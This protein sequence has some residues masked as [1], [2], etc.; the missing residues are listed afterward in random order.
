MHNKSEILKSS[1][2]A[3]EMKQKKRSRRRLYALG[4][5]FCTIALL[6]GFSY[7]SQL[8][9]TRIERVVITGNSTIE[10]DMILKAVQDELFGKYVYLF[11]KQNGLIYPKKK[12]EAHL[13]DVFKRLLDVKIDLTDLHTLNVQ[14][15][16]RDARYLWCGHQYEETI[17]ETSNTQCYYIDGNG[18]I[19]SEAPYFSG[20]VFLKFYGTG[21]FNS[22]ITPVGQQ[23]LNLTDFNALLKF[24]DDV[25]ALGLKTYGLVLDPVGEYH[26]YI[27]PL[28]ADRKVHTK[29]IFN[30]K[31]DLDAIVGNLKAALATEP[32]ATEFKKKFDT[33]LYIDLRFTNKV[34][35]KF[36]DQ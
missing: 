12:I 7:L 31:N 4:I 36:S 21:L 27:S 32:F 28:T 1:S 19:F 34:Y 14:V 33:L 22:S 9:A 15:T 2:R 26:L 5:F 8:R 29:I 10:K 23:F 25:A 18:Y 16:E 24:R 11:S 17:G 35:Y 20:D 30:K 13:L 3:I 6:V